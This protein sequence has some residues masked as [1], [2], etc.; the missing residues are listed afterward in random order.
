MYHTGVWVSNRNLLHFPQFGNLS[1]SDTRGSFPAGPMKAAVIGGVSAVAVV[2]PIH[3]EGQLLPFRVLKKQRRMVI[4][5]HERDQR[6]PHPHGF[7]CRDA[8][9]ERMERLK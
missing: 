7:A 1:E 9:P 8:A 5:R 4:P 6:D 3:H 2:D